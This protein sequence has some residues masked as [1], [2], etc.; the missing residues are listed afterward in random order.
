MERITFINRYR[1]IVKLK[2]MGSTLVLALSNLSKKF[3]IETDALG[4]SIKQR[5]Y[6]M[7]IQLLF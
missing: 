4:T 6:K 3:V 1:N 7:I 2:T 5:S